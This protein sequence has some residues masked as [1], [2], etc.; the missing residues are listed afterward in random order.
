MMSDETLLDAGI[1]HLANGLD[2]RRKKFEIRMRVIRP[3]V[4][5]TFLMPVRSIRPSR[6]EEK[7]MRIA[8][9][10]IVAFVKYAEILRVNAIE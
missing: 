10:W 9:R 3:V 8:A 2:D 7:M 5:A 4:A 1:V 6:A